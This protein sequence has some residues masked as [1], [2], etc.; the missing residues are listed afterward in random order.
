VSARRVALLTLLLPAFAPPARAQTAWPAPSTVP[1]PAPPNP[2]AG[3]Q[4]G[5]LSPPP[6]FTPGERR[7]SSPTEQQLDEARKVAAG[8]GLEWLYLDAEGGYSYVALRAFGAREEAFGQGFLAPLAHG[9]E[10]GVGLGA[11]LL[12]FT[13]GARGRLGF[14]A[15][16]RVWTAGGEAG[17]HVPIGK[18]DPHL[19]IGGGYATLD[20]I[21]DART[22]EASP[23][24]VHGFYARAS[25]G[26]DY[27][28][29]PHVSL[30]GRASFDLLGL[31]R[32]ALDA[33]S[34]EKLKESPS[35]DAAGRSAADA[36]AAAEKSYGASFAATLVVGIH[37]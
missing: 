26:L 11:R 28:L 15:P 35:L 1:A 31:D 6:P 8:R 3:M 16:Y 27:Y 24:A 14:Y 5:G 36:L 4:A 18:L 30:G 12:F 10:V 37:F 7:A 33:A 19:E 21:R 25:A 34:I 23:L 32:A 2:Y 9:G 20:A 22:G 17:F 29:T 13:I